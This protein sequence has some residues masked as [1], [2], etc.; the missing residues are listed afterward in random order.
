IFLFCLLA[1]KEQKYVYYLLL[2]NNV[3]LNRLSVS[4]YGVDKMVNTP[5]K[6]I[7]PYQNITVMPIYIKKVIVLTQ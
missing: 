2:V 5:T 3:L 1:R 4:G 6:F 7:E